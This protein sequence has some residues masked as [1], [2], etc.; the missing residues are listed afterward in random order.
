MYRSY[1]QIAMSALFNLVNKVAWIHDERRKL[2]S[3]IKAAKAR[4]QINQARKWGEIEYDDDLEDLDGLGALFQNYIPDGIGIYAEEE[5]RSK[6][7]MDWI[8]S[9]KLEKLNASENYGM[10]YF[11]SLSSISELTSVTMALL[12][13]YYSQKYRSR[14]EHEAEVSSFIVIRA[15][16]GYI[17]MKDVVFAL[18]CQSSVERLTRACELMIDHKII[19]KCIAEKMNKELRECGEECTD[20]W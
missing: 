1:L 11:G 20:L 3:G 14:E 18:T 4:L 12:E 7:Y 15:L 16:D 2:I 19:L 17:D 5:G 10:S 8:D 13:P 9:S 6:H